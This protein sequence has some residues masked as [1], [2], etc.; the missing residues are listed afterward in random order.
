MRKKERLQK[1][2]SI[3]ICSLT[4]RSVVWE[5]YSH[6]INF[7]WSIVRFI[8]KSIYIF[9]LLFFCKKW[10][11]WAPITIQRSIIF[12]LFFFFF[13]QRWNRTDKALYIWTA[14]ASITIRYYYTKSRKSKWPEVFAKCQVRWTIITSISTF[15]DWIPVYAEKLVNPPKSVGY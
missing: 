5:I 8:K 1:F 13:V 9:A 2:F 3:L 10:T 7:T 14:H 6:L 15:S 11:A 4:R 12:F